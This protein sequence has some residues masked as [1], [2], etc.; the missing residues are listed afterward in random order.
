MMLI[1]LHLL[2]LGFHQYWELP[3]RTNLRRWLSGRETPISPVPADAA[4]VVA[5]AA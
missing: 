4:P 1:V 5:R 3:M 2:A